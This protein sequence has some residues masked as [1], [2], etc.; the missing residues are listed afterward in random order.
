MMHVPR[1]TFV[2]HNMLVDYGVLAERDHVVITRTGVVSLGCT[3]LL[4][5]TLCQLPTLLT[6]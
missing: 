5:D 3:V 1:L 2:K 4:L 6:V